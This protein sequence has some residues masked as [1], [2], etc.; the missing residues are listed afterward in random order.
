[1]FGLTRDQISTIGAKYY[2]EFPINEPPSNFE[3]RTP[4]TAEGSYSS[5]GGYINHATAGSGSAEPDG[6]L[7]IKVTQSSQNKISLALDG[8][9][10]FTNGIAAG[11]GGKDTVFTQNRLSSALTI[12][13]GAIPHWT[14]YVYDILPLVVNSE[15][16]LSKYSSG[17]L[18]LLLREK[19]FVFGLNICTV[20]VDFVENAHSASIVKSSA[21]GP[22]RSGLFRIMK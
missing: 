6:E 8:Y 16:E 22:V 14:D 7:N 5:K 11:F 18:H 13:S 20:E 10:K 1:M 12:W 15:I 9:I 21:R 2:G 4:I 19:T 3:A 17:T